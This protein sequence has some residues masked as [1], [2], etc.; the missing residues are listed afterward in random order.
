MG[1]PYYQKENQN[2]ATGSRLRVKTAAET[3]QHSSSRAQ[4]EKILG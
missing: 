1:Q 2:G 4:G 3:E